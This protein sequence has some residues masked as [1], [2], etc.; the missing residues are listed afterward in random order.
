M[1]LHRHWDPLSFISLAVTLPCPQP[2]A[3]YRVWV[4]VLHPEKALLWILTDVLCSRGA[5]QSQVPCC[6]SQVSKSKEGAFCPLRPQPPSYPMS[7]LPMIP[8]S[9]AWVP[10]CAGPG[11][12]QLTLAYLSQKSFYIQITDVSLRAQRG[13]LLRH[14]TDVNLKST[15][16]RQEYHRRSVGSQ[17]MPVSRAPARVLCSTTVLLGSP[18][19]EKG[20]RDGST[21]E[22]RPTAYVG[23]LEGSSQAE[24]LYFSIVLKP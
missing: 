13:S 10:P 14:I 16:E 18:E 11:C 4:K 9:M 17:F 6:D 15:K 24:Q 22:I 12:K 19:E 2:L 1:I 20:E 7:V 8:C 5:R 21:V 3:A 23:C